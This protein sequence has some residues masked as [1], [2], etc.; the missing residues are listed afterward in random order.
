M[1]TEFMLDCKA[2]FYHFITCILACNRQIN[3]KNA[4]SR[5]IPLHKHF[6]LMTQNSISGLK[7]SELAVA[8]WET[9][10]ELTCVAKTLHC[11]MEGT[12]CAR[13]VFCFVLFCFLT[14]RPAAILFCSSYNTRR[15]L[16]HYSGPIHFPHLIKGMNCQELNF[17]L[18]CSLKHPKVSELSDVH[19][20]FHCFQNQNL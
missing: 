8:F 17:S 4:F 5:V 16:K 19:L 6:M 2:L 3:K 13:P 7:R 1:L 18:A 9:V 14:P 12:L 10:D 15:Q 20:Y 11:I